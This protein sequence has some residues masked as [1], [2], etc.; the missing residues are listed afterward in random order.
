MQRDKDKFNGS[1]NTRGAEGTDDKG[2]AGYLVLKIKPGN[3]LHIG[4]AVIDFKE[5]TNNCVRVAIKAP[6]N[7]LIKKI[8]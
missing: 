4:D 6:R 3:L 7:V 1:E 8:P 5:V 2:L